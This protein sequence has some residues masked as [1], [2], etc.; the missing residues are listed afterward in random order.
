MAN[1]SSRR[2]STAQ[3]PVGEGGEVLRASREVVQAA[4]LTQLGD[5][6]VAKSDSAAERVQ[7]WLLVV[8]ADVL[9]LVCDSRIEDTGRATR[10]WPG[11]SG[12]LTYDEL[13]LASSILPTQLVPERGDPVTGAGTCFAALALVADA[14]LDPPR[15]SMSSRPVRMT[16]GRT[17]QDEKVRLAPEAIPTRTAASMLTA[18]AVTLAGTA[19]SR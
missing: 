6:A 8:R 18:E 5:Q 16:C 12:S 4:V 9:E 13:F 2:A 7:P 11:L 10:G 14:S 1:G 19:S 15:Q 17:E 3:P